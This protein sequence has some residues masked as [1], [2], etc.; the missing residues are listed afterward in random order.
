MLLLDEVIYWKVRGN[1]EPFRHGIND[2][3]HMLARAKTKA[4]SKQMLDVIK[5]P[6]LHTNLFL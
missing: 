1:K 3:E 6:K 4:L 2:K 5:T